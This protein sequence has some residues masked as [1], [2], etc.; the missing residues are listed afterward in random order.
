MYSDAMV[1]TQQQ[2]ALAAS[3]PPVTVSKRALVVS[4]TEKLLNSSG[5]DLRRALFSLK[6]IF[7]VSKVFCVCTW[8]WWYFVKVK[9]FCCCLQFFYTGLLGG[10][11]SCWL[12]LLIAFHKVL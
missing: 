9:P 11:L 3:D 1:V 8:L 4:I 10:S 6:Q 12:S 7:Q 2:R 5:R